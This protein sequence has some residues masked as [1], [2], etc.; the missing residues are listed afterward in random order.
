M[1]PR[2]RL[3]PVEITT[4][5]LCCGDSIFY[6]RRLCRPRSWWLETTPK[7]KTIAINGTLVQGRVDILPRRVRISI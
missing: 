2:E 4:R 5:V 1:G 7:T 6:L 3:R